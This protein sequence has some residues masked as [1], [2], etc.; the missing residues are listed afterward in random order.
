[1]QVPCRHS[2][3]DPDNSGRCQAPTSNPRVK[4][5][6]QSKP[7]WWQPIPLGYNKTYVVFWCK[8][9]K[10]LQL[11]P[12]RLQSANKLG[13][14]LCYCSRNTNPLL[15]QTLPE[16]RAGKTNKQTGKVPLTHCIPTFPGFSVAQAA[17]RSHWQSST[18]KAQSLP[19]SWGTFAASPAVMQPPR[20]LRA[21]AAELFH[22][23]WLWP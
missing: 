10:V 2:G 12:V 6:S 5:N 8:P 13:T 22:P 11:A 14:H 15:S 18:V 19:P 16:Q 3:C 17:S 23:R 7:P 4:I 1:M 21:S 9:Q 20:L